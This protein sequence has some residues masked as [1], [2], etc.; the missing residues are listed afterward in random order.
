MLTHRVPYP[1]DRGDRIRSYHLLKLLSRNFEVA[2]ACTSDEAVTHY[3]QQVLS[4]LAGRLAIQK[5]SKMIT[6]ARGAAA[7]VSGQAVTPSLFYDPRLANTVINWHNQR[8]FDAVLTF[9][10]G[11]IRYARLLTH[12]AHRPRELAGPRPIHVLDLVDV[13]SQKWAAYAAAATGPMK[14]VYGQEA[15]RLARIEAGI[16]DRF[17]RVSVISQP[18]ADT[19]REHLRAHP[20]LAVVEN[21]V[22]LD[23]F[24][25]LPDISSQTAVFV[26]VLNYKPNIEAAQW[27]VREVLPLVRQKLPHAQFQIVGRNPSPRIKAL[28]NHP[29][30]QIVGAVPDVRPYLEGAS[31]VVAPLQVARGVQNKVLE[32]MASQR[33][34]VCSPQAANGI[35]ALPGR[36]LLVGKSPKKF[37]RYVLAL[38]RDDEYRQQVAA[39][40][41]RCV[42]RRYNW[43]QA[44]DPM[45]ELLGGEKTDVESVMPPLADA[46]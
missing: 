16:E 23:Y 25:P 45:I 44:L 12:P 26:G 43:P 33:A 46:A 40:A 32:A 30:V 14:W 13:D 27:Y 19:Y 20:G 8:P 22:D 3:Q 36:H 9:C 42:Q 17:D 38:M 15:K 6:K 24:S 11:M 7:L 5:T 39:A 4:Q 29:G 35:R 18:E 28:K 31:A 37:A 1:P 10:T 21:G 41:R 2:L 34:V